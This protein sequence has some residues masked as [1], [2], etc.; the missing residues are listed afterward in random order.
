MTKPATTRLIVIL[1]CCGVFVLSFILPRHPK[2]IREQTSGNAEKYSSEVWQ[3][4][5]KIQYGASPM[6]G[7]LELRDIADRNPDNAD[8]H[9][10]LGK[11]SVQSGQLDKAEGRFVRVTE[12]E[13]DSLR[14]WYE[15][16]MLYSGQGDFEKA[17]V[18]LEQAIK[19]QPTAE[20]YFARG[21]CF[22]R[23]GDI[24]QAIEHYEKQLLY[25][26]EEK[27][28]RDAEQN[29]LRLTTLTD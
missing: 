4:I 7:M 21:F 19:I 15:L 24:P 18:V 16:G 28:R 3:A 22:E 11:F 8:A 14:G 1:L 12:I 17:T 6:D 29:I 23:L 27:A 9:Y 26:T 5:I 13:P 25:E 10:H 20:L 2:T